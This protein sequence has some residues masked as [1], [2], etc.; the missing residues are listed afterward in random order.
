MSV[1]LKKINKSVSARKRTGNRPLYIV[2][3][4]LKSLT[5]HIHFIILPLS[6]FQ[7]SHKFLTYQSDSHPQLCLLPCCF[8][9]IRLQSGDVPL[10]PFHQCLQVLDP[11]TGSSVNARRHVV[12]VPIVLVD[13]VL[14]KFFLL[15]TTTNNLLCET[16]IG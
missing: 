2:S 14:E 6:F 5:H 8:F 12:V 16:S 11:C 7:L 1:K 4:K 3:V 15:T 9:Y 10:V 13:D